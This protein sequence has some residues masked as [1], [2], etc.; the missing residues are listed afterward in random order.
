[1]KTKQDLLN[2]I[3][4]GVSQTAPWQKPLM[5]KSFLPMKEPHGQREM[6]TV[7]QLL[8]TPSLP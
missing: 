7:G 3:E 5:V 2:K 8:T 1:M 6:N 4:A